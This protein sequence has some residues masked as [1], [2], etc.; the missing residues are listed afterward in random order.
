MVDSNDSVRLRRTCYC[1]PLKGVHGTNHSPA[2]VAAE[3]LA[4][5]GTNQST[6]TTTKCRPVDRAF[7]ATD[8]A[9]VDATNDA[10]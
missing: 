3:Q 10:A 1:Q 9:A 5:D 8:D 6:I 7:A 2:V 4:V